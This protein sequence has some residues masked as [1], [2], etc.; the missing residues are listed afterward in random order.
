MEGR[1]LTA[2]R[3][4]P[5][6]GT[7]FSPLFSNVSGLN[8][9]IHVESSVPDNIIYCKTGQG[10]IM[11]IAEDSTTPFLT[12]TTDER[13]EKL[14]AFVENRAISKQK[15]GLH[16]QWF[17]F[18]FVVAL[19]TNTTTYYLASY[20]RNHNLDRICSRYTSQS[21]SKYHIITGTRLL[22]ICCHCAFH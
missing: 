8:L 10:D 18:C 1:P 4:H 11:N 17:T 12:D 21:I 16:F 13:E 9:S 2:A 5:R 3:L 19:I 20:S 15:R 7:P 14:K 22:C 6:M